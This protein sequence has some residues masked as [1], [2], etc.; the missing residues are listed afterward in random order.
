MLGLSLLDLVLFARHV[1]PPID[2][3]DQW[4]STPAVDLLRERGCTRDQRLLTFG[5]Q[6]VLGGSVA[7]VHGLRCANGITAMVDYQT[8]QLLHALESG[9]VDPRDP[10]FVGEL[11]D[12]ASATSPLLDLLGV[13]FIAANKDASA[14]VAKIPTLEQVHWDP[15]GGSVADRAQ[16]G[17]SAGFSSSSGQKSSPTRTP[18]SPP[19]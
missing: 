18:A 12:P 6:E 10:R 11:R 7:Q 13:R 5:S 17:S 9:L 1:N 19:W 8:G 3:A 4:A 16:H 14:V 2:R 15:R